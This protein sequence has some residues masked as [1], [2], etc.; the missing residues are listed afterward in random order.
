MSSKSGDMEVSITN[1][2]AKIV[3]IITPDKNGKT[4]DDVLGFDNIDDYLTKEPFFGA[5]LRP[6]LQPDQKG[7]FELERRS[8]DLVSQ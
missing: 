8:Y 6:F 4:D 5:R 1:F 7:H 3:S 2:G